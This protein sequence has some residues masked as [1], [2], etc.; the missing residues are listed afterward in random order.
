M[1]KRIKGE[2]LDPR[3]LIALDKRFKDSIEKFESEINRGISTLCIL[4]VIYNS[5]KKGVHGYQILKDL[6]D[7]TN[8]IL[9]IGIS[10]CGLY[11]IFES[12]IHTLIFKIE[13]N[14]IQ[15]LFTR[16][17]HEE[18]MRLFV[19]A[20]II[21]FSIYT[22][23]ILNKR[24]KLS[25]NLEKSEVK[26]R[27]IFKSIPDLFFLSSSDT[28]I[29]DYKGKNEDLY[30]PPELFLGKKIKDFMPKEITK[31]YSN[32]IKKTIET[33]QPNT[34][35]Y[36]LSLRDETHYY[37]ARNLYFSK[38]QVAIFIRDITERKLAEEALKES[39]QRLK[40]AQA[41][42]KMGYWEF[43]IDN[44]KIFWS[45]QVFKLY[46]RDLSLGAPTPEEEA[47]YYSPMEA[48]RLREYARRAIEYAKGFEYDFEA[49]L[50]NGRS[51]QLTTLMRPIREKSGRV[52]KL[53]GTVQDITV[54][55]KAEEEI[56]EAKKF[57]SN[58]FNSIQDGINIID[59]NFNIISTNPA[60]ERWYSNSKP[61]IGKKCYEIYQQRTEVC[62]NCPS[63]ITMET[64][65]KAFS[66]VDKKAFDGTVIGTL[67]VFTFPL[68]DQET[69]K[70]RGVIEH[71]RDI[72]ERK[73]AEEKLKESEEKYR[74]LVKSSPNS[75]ILL[76]LKGNIIDCNNFTEFYFGLAREE[77]IGKN[78][79]DLY[80]VPNEK[81]HIVLKQALK[82][83]KNQITDPIEFT[84][85]NKKGETVWLMNFFSFVKIGDHKYIQFVSEDITKR[86][87]VENMIK[88]QIEK[89]KELD[90]VKNE[91]VYRASHELKTPLTSIYGASELLMKYYEDHFD[92]RAKSLVNIINN[93]GKRLNNLIEDL[94]DVSKMESGKL[95]LKK[96]KENIIEIIKNCLNDML[97]LVKE[98]DLSLSFDFQRDIYIEVDKI[99]IEQVIMNL[100]SNA[101]KN[102]PPK[103]GLSIKLNEYD[104]FVNLKITD[105]G[106]GFTEEE[107]EKVFKKF[108][109]IE[110]YGKGMDIIT[111]GSGLGLFI[112][113]E[114]VKLHHGEIWLESEGR[115]RGSTFIVRVPS[116]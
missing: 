110:R 101:I 69:G 51:I 105:T 83:I 43:D 14:F 44:Q 52:F 5:N 28:T 64:G 70:I 3:S 59:S 86:K 94:I 68:L 81:K 85:I 53:I 82:R 97:F 4:S 1:I 58:I 115:N 74:T 96:Q 73:K 25:Q 2:E 13:D 104:G 35:E 32:A 17:I 48:K 77:I 45:D 49:N 31:L 87:E 63:K 33:Q 103:G 29:L 102:T 50:P 15:H 72:T 36:Y 56:R 10:L 22:Q 107:K 61:L 12:L 19:V 84:F 92:D 76:D 99:R 54:R 100:I 95:E 24:R 16:D 60:I 65:E 114:I 88:K 21:I 7:Q 46:K 40:D 113:K 23:K 38:N 93:G 111:E 108:G 9:V 112:S 41:L 18:W 90:Q 57:L 79:T 42:G 109:K 67:E 26:F 39:E 71:I 75:I 30:I 27:R 20:L 47:T 89:L 55:K 91:F 37:E 8:K 106:V 11:W 34:I 116:S 6:G 98:R 66:A 62:E 80:M 78:F